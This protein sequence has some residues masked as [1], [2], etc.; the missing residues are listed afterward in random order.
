M[1]RAGPDYARYLAV[2]QII[3]Y[4]WHLCLN[5]GS[6]LMDPVVGSMQTAAITLREPLPVY[7]QHP[8]ETWV[9]GVS[10]VFE[11]ARGS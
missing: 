4:W 2:S 11:A 3:Q 6:L 7:S 10:D 8:N 1:R 5:S 9:I